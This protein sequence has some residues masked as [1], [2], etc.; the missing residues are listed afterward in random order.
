MAFFK[1]IPGFR[2]LPLKTGLGHSQGTKEND[3][4]RHDPKDRAGNHG[5]GAGEMLSDHL[6][7]KG[8]Q[9]LTLASFGKRSLR[10]KMQ[11]P[12]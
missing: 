6:S 9:G 1:G 5:H 12:R 2:F 3:S 4:K 8:P 7:E 11:E 10:R